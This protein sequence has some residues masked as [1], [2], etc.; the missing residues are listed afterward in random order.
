MIHINLVA[1]L[2]VYISS[3]NHNTYSTYNYANDTAIIGLN[4]D[5]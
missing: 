5:E 4:M 3:L 2:N 1:L